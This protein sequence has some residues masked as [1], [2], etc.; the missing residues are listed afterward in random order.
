MIRKEGNLRFEKDN[1]KILRAVAPQRR[2]VKS[3]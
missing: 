3:T 2:V 1:Q